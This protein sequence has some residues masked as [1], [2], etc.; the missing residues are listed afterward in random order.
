MV[1]SYR[2]I[3]WIQI[4]MYY[5]APVGELRV[6]KT[7]YGSCNIPDILQEKISDLFKGY[8]IVHTY[9]DD[10]LVITK[11]YF[12]EPLKALEKALHKSLETG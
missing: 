2:F 5:C 3:P 8:D 4:D 1:F 12:T 7:T 10:V 11:K 6:P 9:I